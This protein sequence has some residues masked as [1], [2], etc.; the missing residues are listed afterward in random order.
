MLFT[1]GFIPALILLGGCSGSSLD[2]L[3]QGDVILAFGDSL[4]YG[5]GVAADL[6]YPVVLE[7]I[8]GY[9]V[10]RSGVPGEISSAGLKRLPGILKKENPRLVVICHGGN[11]VLRRL[12]RQQT[13]ANLRSMIELVRQHGA[14]VILIAVPKISLFPS[15]AKFYDA[16]E[17]DTG[18]P[19]EFD[20][21]SQLQTDSKMKSDP[22]HFNRLGYR[23]MAEAVRDLLKD[24]GAI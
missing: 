6:S 18:V 22:I 21:L 10:I 15:A 11:D 5:T 1:R 19:V 8:T 17:E 2:P 9:S 24:N 3:N 4:T 14:Q 13:E 16:I 23:K 20:I 7:S 12:N